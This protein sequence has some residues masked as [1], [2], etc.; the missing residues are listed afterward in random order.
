MNQSAQQGISVHINPN[1]LASSII[2]TK[3]QIKLKLRLLSMNSKYNSQK[4]SNLVLCV[5]T[6]QQIRG[7][8][9]EKML[10]GKNMLRMFPRSQYKVLYSLI[11]Q[12]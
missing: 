5:T 10:L 7:F 3:E 6:R 4:F 12:Y 11:K 8:F 1:S 2:D 9:F